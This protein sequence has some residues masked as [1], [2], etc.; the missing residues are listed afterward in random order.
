MEP[1]IQY[2]KTQDGVNIAFWTHGEGT[3]LVQMPL[4]LVSSIQ[5]EWHSIDDR[6]FY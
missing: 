5:S 1:R 6:R 4:Q 3:P 2:A